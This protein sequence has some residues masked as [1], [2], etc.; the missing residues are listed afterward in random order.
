MREGPKSLQWMGY[1]NYGDDKTYLFIFRICTTSTH[2]GFLGGSS[3][4][5]A[6]MY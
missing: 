2:Y 1:V 3:L 4:Q 6:S 5:L